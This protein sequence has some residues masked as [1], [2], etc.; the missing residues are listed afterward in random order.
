M[1]ETTELDLM[2]RHVAEAARIRGLRTSVVTY[3]STMN[4]KTPRP[5]L[6]FE[7]AGKPYLYVAG[8]LLE[9]CSAPHGVAQRRNINHQAILL[10]R[11]KHRLKAHLSDNGV[12]VPQG[13]MFRRRKLDMARAAFDSFQVP[14]CVKPNNGSMGK[15]VFPGI[16]ERYWYDAA[17]ESVAESYP[18]IIV[19]QSVTG[20]HYRF[21]YIAPNVAA[22]RIGRPAEVVGDGVSNVAALVDARNEERIRR[23]L[24]N[25]PPLVVSD[26]ILMN[27]GM[28]GMTLDTVPAPGQS[29]SL[30]GA[31][32]E[33]AGADVIVVDMDRDIHPSYRRVVEEACKTV[34]GLHF[35]GVDI[36]IADPTQ[37]AQ[38]DNHWILELNGSPGILEYYYH[39]E[40]TVIDIA[41][42]LL[43]YLAQRPADSD[44]IGS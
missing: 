22:I 2:A 40:G 5:W 42:S 33:H 11:D 3:G 4:G 16:T 38:P 17:L 28:Q 9:E 36:V 13:Q 19:E 14:V 23:A 44:E 24:P 26:N 34:P 30:W 12:S 6:R 15:C 20:L 32:N 25:H 43:D 39:W 29:V 10:M 27:L 8:A 37:P 31:S 35:S 41:G 21:F 7:I 18:T 1:Q